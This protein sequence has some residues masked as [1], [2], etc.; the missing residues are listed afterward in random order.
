MYEENTKHPK[1]EDYKPP[2]KGKKGKNNKKSKNPKI[3]DNENIKES[4]RENE[5]KQKTQDY[6]IYGVKK[7]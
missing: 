5:K 7:T 6:R 3:P 1:R 2:K 4:I